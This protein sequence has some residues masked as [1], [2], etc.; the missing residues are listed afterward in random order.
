MQTGNDMT[1]DDEKEI[2][3]YSTPG[4]REMFPLGEDGYV[5][6]GAPWKWFVAKNGSGA[7]TLFAYDL[8]KAEYRI[9]QSQMI[10]GAPRLTLRIEHHG[11]AP[12]WHAHRAARHASAFRSPRHSLGNRDVPVLADAGLWSQPLT[13]RIRAMF[14]FEPMGD[15]TFD[16]LQESFDTFSQETTLAA[17]P[18]GAAVKLDDHEHFGDTPGFYIGQLGQSTPFFRLE[19]DGTT[20]PLLQATGLLPRRRYVR[21]E[22]ILGQNGRNILFGPE[23][24][25]LFTPF[26]PANELASRAEDFAHALA[27]LWAIRVENTDE[28]AYGDETAW[29][30][31][32]SFVTL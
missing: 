22:G 5:H 9:W 29:T 13:D 15:E 8:R 28:C 6:F 21:P 18:F 26:F 32:P 27:A 4:P 19:D 31:T 7:R 1:F 23:N 17:V 30:D 10:D 12:G 2:Q 16:I 3:W 24:R 11:V 20:I 25:C 14:P